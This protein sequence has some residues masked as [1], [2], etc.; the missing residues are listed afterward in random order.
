MEVDGW[1]WHVDA[2][3]FRADRRK[4]N[5]LVRAGVGSTAVH[6]ARA[7]WAAP[8]GRRGDPG[9]RAGRMI[10][11]RAAGTAARAVFAARTSIKPC[12]RGADEA[13][14]DHHV[15]AVAAGGP[16]ERAPARD[17]PQ[18]GVVDVAVDA[19]GRER[20][21]RILLDLQHLEPRGRAVRPV[22]RHLGSGLQVAQVEEHAGGVV[23]VD[24][25]R[26]HRGPVLTGCRGAGEPA[27]DGPV[28]RNL[29][30]PVGRQP[31]R[32]QRRVDPDRRDADAYGRGRGQCRGG[33]HLHRRGG[34][35]ACGRDRGGRAAA[36][37]GEQQAGAEGDGT[38][39]PGLPGPHRDDP[40]VP[41][42]VP[43]A[44]PVCRFGDAGVRARAVD[45]I[46]AG[47]G[48]ARHRGVR[49]PAVDVGV[50][51]VT[52][53]ARNARSAGRP[54]PERDRAGAGRGV[55]HGLAPGV[56]SAGAQGDHRTQRA[57]EQ[58]GRD[59]V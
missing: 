58:D 16:V 19:L 34:W 25:R 24:V 21:L 53:R 47:P 57:D 14:V 42:P 37:A 38:Q 41:V 7:R 3:R 50:A 20:V 23:P 44:M 26:D 22:D 39:Q 35:G 48:G 8:A 56:P 6:L 54:R 10:D 18:A 2:E 9:D 52:G 11:M 5:A 15:V 59:R 55:R 33:Q 36:A 12:R 46:R 29:Q 43:V 31:Q 32:D 28:D 45:R 30:R 27:C 13:R 40:A 51:V 17:Q 1:A 49:P 4:Q